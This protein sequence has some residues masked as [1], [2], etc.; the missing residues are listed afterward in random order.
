MADPNS[1][2]R[3]LWIPPRGR[4][5]GECW[6]ATSNVVSIY[7][8]MGTVFVELRRTTISLAYA[9]PAEAERA[10][11]LFVQATW[12]AEPTAEARAVY[13]KPLDGNIRLH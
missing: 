7:A 3:K 12:V 4:V 11:D 13:P 5:L 10:R 1:I 2:P 6:V 8:A 9:N